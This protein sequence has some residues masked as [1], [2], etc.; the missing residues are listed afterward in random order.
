LLLLQRALQ[1]TEAQD[2]GKPNGNGAHFASEPLLYRPEYQE[3]PPTHSFSGLKVLASDQSLPSHCLHYE[4]F[5]FK[6]RGDS[7]KKI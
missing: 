2:H 1:S 4:F 5:S 7:K 3:A 6:N